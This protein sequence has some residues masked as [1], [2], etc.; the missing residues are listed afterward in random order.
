MCVACSICFKTCVILDSPGMQAR[1]GGSEIFL[2]HR[3][4][5]KVLFVARGGAIG[6]TEQIHNVRLFF[7]SSRQ[8]ALVSMS[9]CFDIRLRPIY[10]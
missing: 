3:D 5:Q 8:T 1:G 2:Y 4:F 6:V 9:F 7:H 10:Y